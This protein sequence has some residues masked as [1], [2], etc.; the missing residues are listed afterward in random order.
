MAKD[1]T[2]DVEKARAA[3]VI[4]ATRKS[5]LTY[6]ELGAAIGM[7]GVNLRNQMRHVLDRLS[8]DC[9][10]YHEPSLAA[11][12]VKAESGEPGSGWEGPWSAT[13]RNVFDF[14]WVAAAK[15]RNEQSRLTSEQ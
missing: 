15:F 3:L 1:W 14:D 5:I 8:E 10:E 4:A 11:L 2:H 9:D 12:V 6:G 7:T 13:V